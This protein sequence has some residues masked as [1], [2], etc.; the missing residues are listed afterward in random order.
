MRKMIHPALLMLCLFGSAAFAQDW[1]KVENKDELRGSRMTGFFVDGSAA[2]TTFGIICADG[3]FDHVAIGV[4][5]VLDSHPGAFDQP[6]VKVRYKRDDEKPGA[7]TGIVSKDGLSVEVGKRYAQKM[8]SSST[9]KLVIEVPRYAQGEAQTVFSFPSFQPVAEACRGLFVEGFQSGHRSAQ[10]ESPTEETEGSGRAMKTVAVAQAQTSQPEL[11]TE[12]G[13]Y[14]EAPDGLTKVIGEIAEFKRTGSLFV[15]GLTGGIKTKKENIQLLGAHAQTVVSPQ[16]VFYF[17][18]TTQEVDT[19]ENAENLILMRLEEKPS[20]RQFEIGAEGLWRKSAGLTVTHQV[21]LFRSE[22]APG[23]FKVMPAEE[24]KKGEYALYL[25]RNEGTPAYLY[26]FSV[27]ATTSIARKDNLSTR[28]PA[29]VEGHPLVD[30]SNA[31]HTGDSPAA[32]QKFRNATI[33]A[34]FEGNP[35]VRRNGIEVTAVTPGGPTQQ[36]G[37]SV[38]DVIVA[39]NDRFLYTI[40]DLTEEIGRHEPGTTIRVR[41]HRY[42]AVNEANVVVG[43]VQ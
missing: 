13:M 16:P 38:G 39:V 28:T 22:V 2:D 26:D 40:R 7:F 8:I 32:P 35:D 29:L 31:K 24:L 20:R 1:R 6:S 21:Q 9:R 23:V 27:Q 19:G 11:P 42:K 10:E 17:V 34:F 25:W 15:H 12:P 18:P 5:A 36:A 41:Y 37:M 14:V 30:R 4:G 3:K 43:Q 33:G